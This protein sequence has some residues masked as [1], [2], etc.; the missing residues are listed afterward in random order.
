MF[1]G[2]FGF[3]GEITIEE[4]VING[5]AFLIGSSA[6]GHV[7]NGG[8]PSGPITRTVAFP[9]GIEADDIALLYVEVQ[10]DDAVDLDSADWTLLVAQDGGSPSSQL[11]VF[12]IRCD[13]DTMPDVVITVD[14]SGTGFG[15]HIATQMHVFRGAKNEDSP[16]NVLASGSNVS[17]D[18]TPNP[19]GA[20]TTE[21]NCLAI[22]ALSVGLDTSGD[23]DIADQTFSAW[24]NADLVDFHQIADHRTGARGGG[25][26]GIAIGG[27]VLSGAFG[28]SNVT[29]STATQN[30]FV[31]IALEPQSS[32]GPSD[33][34]A[35][36]IDDI[37]PDSDTVY[38]SSIL[39]AKITDETGLAL[40]LIVASFPDGSAEVVHD[41]DEFRGNYRGGVNDRE[42]VTGGYRYT[43]RRTGGWVQ[44]PSLEYYALDGGGNLA[45]IA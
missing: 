26:F 6:F 4:T 40:V 3:A 9:D 17:N 16:V 25:G 33:S 42:A 15:D 37:S 11:H 29:Q 38:A 30:A 44:S 10:D 1:G 8:V 39:S 18:T 24:S 20:T 5:P 41:G 22:V 19:V 23:T 43:I 12:W 13:S 34:V 35:P 2:L 7:G 45:E 31:T 36:V 32:T 21:D 14:N 27:K 28:V